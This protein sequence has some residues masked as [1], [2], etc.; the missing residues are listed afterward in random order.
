MHMSLVKR[1]L[2]K[3]GLA[4]DETKIEVNLESRLGDAPVTEGAAVREFVE[5][6]KNKSTAEGGQATP[7]PESNLVRA[8]KEGTL[9]RSR[10]N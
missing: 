1:L 2:A 4:A 7:A 6:I 9:G 10:I 8:S 3:V 5:S